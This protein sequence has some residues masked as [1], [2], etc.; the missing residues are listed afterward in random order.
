ME[1]AIGFRE[2]PIQKLDQAILKAL[3]LIG[4]SQPWTEPTSSP[5]T[6]RLEP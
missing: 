2:Y 5:T 3:A 4:E 1:L 6:L